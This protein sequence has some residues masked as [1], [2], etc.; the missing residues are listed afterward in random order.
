MG[1]EARKTERSS[2]KRGNGAY[3]GY[4]WEAKNE[5]NRSLLEGTILKHE[6]RRWQSPSSGSERK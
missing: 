4:R 6:A 5:S 2:P 1:Y 3:W